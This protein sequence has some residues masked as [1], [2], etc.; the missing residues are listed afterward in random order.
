MQTE[1]FG[2][3]CL[4]TC[5]ADDVF[6]GAGEA[7]VQS[8]TNVDLFVCSPGGEDEEDDACATSLDCGLSMVCV[9]ASNTCKRLCDASSNADCETGEICEAF[10]GNASRGSCIPDP[11]P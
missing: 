4:N 10:V 1:T 8:E 9:D 11:D 5:T 6:C 3:V 7:C 2:R